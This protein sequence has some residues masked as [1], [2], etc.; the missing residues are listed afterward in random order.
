MSAKGHKYPV[1][2]PSCQYL[3]GKYNQIVLTEVYGQ[4]IAQKCETARSTRQ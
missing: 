4:N 1:A 2:Y 3:P